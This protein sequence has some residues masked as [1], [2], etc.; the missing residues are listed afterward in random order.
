MSYLEELKTFKNK[1]WRFR[2]REHV[3]PVYW[4]DDHNLFDPKESNDAFYKKV[5]EARKKSKALYKWNCSVEVLSSSPITH[6][7]T[8]EGGIEI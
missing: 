5:A 8:L 6:L 3:I 2:F 1:F 4:A 7:N